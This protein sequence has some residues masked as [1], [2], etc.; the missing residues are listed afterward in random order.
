MFFR[1]KKCENSTQKKT[2]DCHLGFSLLPLFFAF[3]CK[4]LFCIDQN[5][6]MAAAVVTRTWIYC[7]KKWQW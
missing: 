7:V 6:V 4:N 2:P 1:L 5:L 3:L